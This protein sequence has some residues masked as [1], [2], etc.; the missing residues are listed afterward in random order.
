MRA[1]AEALEGNKVKLSV[2]VDEAEMESAVEST[3]R[4]MAASVRVPGFRPGKVPRKVLEAKLGSGSLRL[5]AIQDALPGF[6]ATA[7]RETEVDAI[8]PPEIDITAGREAGPVGFDAVVEVRPTVSV[9]GYEGLQVTLDRLEVDDSDVRAQIDRIRDQQARLDVVEREARDGDHV[10][11]DI[12]ADRAGERVAGMSAEG[13]VYEVGSG[14]LNPELDEALRGAKAGDDLTF[15]GAAPDGQSATFSVALKAVAEKVA[16][17]VD[18]AWAAE[19]SEFETLEALEAD[20]RRRLGDAKRSAA[21][22][23]V[24]DRALEALIGLVDEDPPTPMVESRLEEKIH[25][26]GH[27]LESQGVSIEQY[28]ALSGQDGAGLIAEIRSSAEQDIRGDLALRAL[29][30]ALDIVVTDDDLEAEY[31]LIAESVGQPI[32]SVK[33][34]L[35]R[36]D[37]VTAVRSELRKGR[38]LEWLVANVAIVDQDGKPVDRA[39]LQSSDGVDDEVDGSGSED[40]PP[41]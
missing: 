9:A 11:I 31:A 2:E 4:R 18:D 37:R 36:N 19:N 22:E 35:V 5:E 21:R 17:V 29:A 34:Q 23:M 15:E 14:E 33:E 13:I 28:L 41:A 3:Y 39:E 38:A 7:L 26:F 1:T 20:I 6:Y 25:D 12:H 8:A 32:E 30:D 16:P 27:R 40:A 24:R 10:T